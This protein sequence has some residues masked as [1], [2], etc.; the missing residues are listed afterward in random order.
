[1]QVSVVRTAD[2]DVPT[3]SQEDRPATW[4]SEETSW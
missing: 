2:G 1:M 3:V 4:R